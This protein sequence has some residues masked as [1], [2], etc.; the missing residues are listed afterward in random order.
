MKYFYEQLQCFQFS[1]YST[2]TVGSAEMRAA[3]SR[4]T[5]PSTGIVHVAAAVA[6]GR[7]SPCAGPGLV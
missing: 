7:I 5:S 4:T 1:C 3:L 2:Q 6:L